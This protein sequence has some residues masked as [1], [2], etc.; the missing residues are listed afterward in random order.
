MW[1]FSLPN[2]MCVDCSAVDVNYV[3]IQFKCVW[4]GTTVNSLLYPR[5]VSRVRRVLIRSLVL[6]PYLHT[7]VCKLNVRLFGCDYYK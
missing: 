3:S 2:V 5:F 6:K 1:N 7:N 4:N